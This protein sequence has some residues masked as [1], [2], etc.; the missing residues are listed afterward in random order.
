MLETIWVFR[1]AITREVGPIGRKLVQGERQ[2][3]K[4]AA[5][6]YLKLSLVAPTVRGSMS[7]A[8]ITQGYL[9]EE[10]RSQGLGSARFERRIQEINNRASLISCPP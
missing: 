2:S 9:S 5:I 3:L 7:E 8:G 1:G 6:A 4:V 10:K